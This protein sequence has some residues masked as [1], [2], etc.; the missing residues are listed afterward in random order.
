MITDFVIA[1]CV[2]TKLHIKPILVDN[3][4]QDILYLSNYK[5]AHLYGIFEATRALLTK[6]PHNP[7]NHKVQISHYTRHGLPPHAI[8]SPGQASIQAALAGSNHEYLYFVAKG[9]GFSYFSLTLAEHNAA[10]KRYQL[11][12]NTT[13]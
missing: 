13:P 3:I 4:E 9:D 8:C 10:V 11:N 12:Q 6:K 2:R 7:W 5:E 1:Y